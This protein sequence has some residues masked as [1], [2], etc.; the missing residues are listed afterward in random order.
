MICYAIEITDPFLAGDIRNPRPGR[1]I[2]LETIRLTKKAAWSAFD[3]PGAWHDYRCD[4][5]VV[6]V[7][8]EGIH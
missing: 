5:M 4:P 8:V 2:L 1:R 7:C 3:E 6:D